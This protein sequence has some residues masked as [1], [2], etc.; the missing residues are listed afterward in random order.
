M[1]KLRTDIL[2][3]VHFTLELLR[4]IP[5][6]RQITARE[7]HEQLQA[8]GIERDVRT[9]QRQLEHLSR[10]FDI[11]RDER[12]RPFGYR[13]KERAKG[14]SLPG[15]SEQE[16]LLLMLAQQYL[17]NLLPARLMRSMDGFFAQAHQTLELQ[18]NAQMARQWLKKV[19]MVSAR[20]PLL[21]PEIRPGVLE[22][23]SNALYQN[24]WLEVDYENQQK[25]RRQ[26]RVMPLGLVQQ[27]CCLYL[28][29][30]FEGYDNERNLAL[31]RLHGVVATGQGFDRPAF[32]LEKYDADGRFGFGEGHRVR[33]AFCIDKEAG[34]HLLESR[35][36]RD[37]QV[38]ERQDCYHITATVVDSAMLQ[39]WLNGFGEDVWEVQRSPCEEPL[40]S[41]ASPAP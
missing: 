30:R 27:G 14:L 19:R 22:A 8:A 1:P 37:Q 41:A 36:S 6:H 2:D 26:S 16:S 29:C 31:H 39:W 11:E 32:D 28:V 21:P 15:L 7:L 4:R 3:T 20:Q 35:L 10:H 17:S 23:V 13:W 9:I 24:E 40:T 33:L 25:Q 12:S 34:F 18:G 5:R 38:Q